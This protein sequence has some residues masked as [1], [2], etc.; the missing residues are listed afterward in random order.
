MVRHLAPTGYLMLGHAE[1]LN[2][3]TDHLRAVAPTIYTTPTNAAETQ[4]F[5][6]SRFS[7]PRTEL[8]ALP[9]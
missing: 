3:I 6:R 1:T 9:Y 2:G 8:R 7:V 5:T 4:I